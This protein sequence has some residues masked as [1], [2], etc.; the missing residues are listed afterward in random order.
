[1]TLKYTERSPIKISLFCYDATYSLSTYS[2]IIHQ[3][4]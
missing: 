1:M 3:H 2:H 4:R